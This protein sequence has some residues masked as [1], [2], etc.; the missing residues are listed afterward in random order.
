MKLA[1]APRTVISAAL[2]LAALFAHAS[3]Q[4]VEGRWLTEPR[5]GIVDIYRCEAGALCGRLV[6]VLIKP[7][8]EN[9]QATDNHNPSAA[10]RARPL[11]GLQ[12]MSGFNPDGQA[13]WSGGS[14]YDPQSG[15]TYSANMT[16]RSDGTLGVRGYIGT[17]LLGRT[18]DWTRYAGNPPRCPSFA[19]P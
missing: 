4:E 2:L 13:H 8:D 14:I 10:L 3:A 6:W 12:I 15:K 11:C 18:Q 17:P 5:N 19:S 7:S 9:P 1:N 16:L